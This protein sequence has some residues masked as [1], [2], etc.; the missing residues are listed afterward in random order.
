MCEPKG[1]RTATSL[2]PSPFRSPMAVSP[3]R[4]DDEMPGYPTPF[5]KFNSTLSATGLPATPPTDGVKVAVPI[6][7]PV[8]KPLASTVTATELSEDQIAGT[9]ANGESVESRS[10]ALNWVVSP[11]LIVDK[12]RLAFKLR[13]FERPPTIYPVNSSLVWVL[14][15]FPVITN[16]CFT[17]PISCAYQS[18]STPVTTTLVPLV[19]SVTVSIMLVSIRRQF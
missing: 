3:K 15:P 5:L 1:S 6:L 4:I 13:P 14:R 9:I 11:S 16:V 19:E 12:A 10:V 2:R 7:F 18:D 8:A 17:G